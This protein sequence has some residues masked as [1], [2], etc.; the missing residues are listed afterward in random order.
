MNDTF[1]FGS[2]LGLYP[3]QGRAVHPNSITR[4]TALLYHYSWILCLNLMTEQNSIQ[5][6]ILVSVFA[7]CLGARAVHH[8]LHIHHLS[9]ISHQTK[10][11][12]FA[13]SY[14]VIHPFVI[15]IIHHPSSPATTSQSMERGWCIRREV[16]IIISRSK[17]NH[18]RLL[19]GHH[20]IPPF[21]VLSSSALLI[22]HGR[23]LPCILQV[24]LLCWFCTMHADRQDH[25][26]TDG[27][28][29]TCVYT[30]AAPVFTRQP[31]RALC[32]IWR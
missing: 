3:P 19:S 24:S 9:S 2:K 28:I 14:K 1:L 21:P 32:N 31:C 7:L 10:Y 29:G 25:D 20:P 22:S 4:N 12:H 23:T 8:T 18:R 11:T 6:T 26:Q 16:T 17:L 27:I 5:W 30:I 13:P 15:I